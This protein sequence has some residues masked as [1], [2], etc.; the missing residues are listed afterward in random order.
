MQASYTRSVREGNSRRRGTGVAPPVGMKDLL[1]TS[2]LSRRD[3]LLLLELAARFKRRP[4]L[5]T[6]SLKFVTS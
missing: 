4:S 2:D 1:R 6:A 5:S 3:L